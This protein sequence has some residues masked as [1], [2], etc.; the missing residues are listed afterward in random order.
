MK[1]YKSPLIRADGALGMLNAPEV[2]FIDATW[3]MPNLPKNARSEYV[4]QHI[5]GAVY[6][7][8][9]EVADKESEL[10]HM[11]PT[12]EHFESCVG[13]MGISLDNHLIVYDRGNY[14]ASARVWWM[15]K[16][17]GH[18]NVQVLD[19]GLS[20]WL[21][22]DGQCESGSSE[23]EPQNYV[24]KSPDRFIAAWSDIVAG[25]SD[26]STQIVDARSPGRFNG[27]E[28]E[29]RPGLRGGHIPNS[30]NLYYMDVINQDGTMK[31]PEEIADLM[32]FVI[33]DEDDPI[34]TTCGSGV[35]ASILL[36]AFHQV[37]PSA[38]RL[39]DGSW[40]EWAMLPES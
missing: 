40:T 30:T 20:A 38:L 7:D 4:E 24:A 14:V 28:P 36:L 17:F 5:P 18:K 22:A 8:I 37:R 2:I 23:I 21:R 9:D 13:E 32:E 25:I 15:F 12:I 39:Y 33:D 26:A 6:F 27:T 29:P 16:S 10:P 3:Y 34:I 11:F 35:T 31:S 19:G 1:K